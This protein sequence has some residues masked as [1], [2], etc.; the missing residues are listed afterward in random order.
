LNVLQKLFDK[1]YI[2]KRDFGTQLDMMNE[3]FE[4]GFATKPLL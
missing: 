2:P 4:R 1:V 3:S